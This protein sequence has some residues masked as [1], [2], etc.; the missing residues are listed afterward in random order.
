MK[1]IY[2]NIERLIRFGLENSFFEKEDE[3]YIR[4]KILE[5]LNITNYDKPK[6][7]ME[8][9]EYACEILDELEAYAISKEIISNMEF[10]KD[11]F[12]AKIM[13]LMLP[14]PSTINFIF[15]KM[16]K[17]SS[18]DATN[19]FF[20]FSRKSNY[21]QTDRIA[22]NINYKS[23]SKYGDL[24]I[25][26]NLSKPEKDAREIA[27]LKN[28][29]ED[30]KYPLTPIAIENE[31][32]NGTIKRAARQNLRVVHLNIN[33]ELWHFQYSPYSYYDEHSILFSHEIRDMKI[34]R[35]CFSNLLTF[36]DK[37]EG[38]FIGSNADLPIV[39]GSILNHDH[40][41]CGKYVFPIEKVKSRKE[42]KFE[43]FEN[44]KA[45][46]VDWPLTVIRLNASKKHKKEILD[47]ADLILK[48]WK[49]HDDYI[50]DIKSH[51]KKTPHNTITPIARMNNGEYELDLILRNNATSKE[52][53]FGIFHISEK[54][55]N[56][57]KENIG[58]IEAMGLAI[59][60]SRLKVEMEGIDEI[61][62]SEKDLHKALEKIS[63]DENLNKHTNFVKENFEK[64]FKVKE[65]YLSDLYDY[66]GKSFEKFL[67]EAGVYKK[68]EVGE[69]GLDRFL[70]T[71]KR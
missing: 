27:M 48:R 22:K 36:L 20:N 7:E 52:K 15:N 25:S 35:K 8:I 37:M 69:K 43:G 38:Y 19:Y 47:L 18:V 1:D 70:A 66:I 41:Q 71:V 68:N 45:N 60:P 53:P 44:V 14:T 13:D 11:N 58:L 10:D 3:I 50:N 65:S 40:Y 51:T 39:G 26:I 34:D 32:V 9:P 63:K 33:R 55:F 64:T 59:L 28:S 12:R 67:E 30:S 54:D 49:K 2:Y 17:K 31:G 57:K 61:L 56:I 16:K 4:N 29:K 62:K 42:I 24:E 46:I 5:L 23:K 21:I 6:E